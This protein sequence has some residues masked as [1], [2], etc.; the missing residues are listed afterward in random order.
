MQET[1]DLPFSSRKQTK[2]PWCWER[3]RAG[4]EADDRGWDGGMASPTQWT[5]VWVDSRSWWWTGRPGVLWFM[6]LQRVGHDWVTELNWFLL[7]PNTGLDTV[8]KD[9]DK[10]VKSLCPEE[11]YI[12]ALHPIAVGLYRAISWWVSPGWGQTNLGKSHITWTPRCLNGHF[13]LLEAET[14]THPGLSH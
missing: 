1:S 2:R 3:L 5:W 4:G 7:L 9:M 8:A 13:A 12:P 10:T 6:G 14:K 11:I